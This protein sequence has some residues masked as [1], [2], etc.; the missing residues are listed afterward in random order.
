VGFT[1]RQIAAEAKLADEAAL[2]ALESVVPHTLVQAVVARFQVGQRRQRK[3]PAELV[4]LLT[5]AMSL[6]ATH[7]LERVLAKLLKGLRFIWPEP[8]FALPGRSAICQ[9]RYRLGARPVAA[10]F[11]HVCRPMAT[12]A[13]QGAFYAGLRLMAIDSTTEDVPDS[14][15]N[16]RAFG[17]QTGYR[18]DGA[19]PQVRAVYLVECGSHAIVDAGLWPCHTSERVG[20]LRLLRS[21][22]EGM[23]LLWDSGLHSFAMAAATQR[24]G[25]H[26]LGR[27]PGFA[28]FQPCERLGDG[29]YLTWLYPSYHRRKAG[30]RMLVRLVEYTLSDPARPGYA[31]RHRLLTS[32]LDPGHHPA[33]EL[34]CLYHERWEVELVVDETDTHTRGPHR[35]LRSQRPVGVVQEWYGL[36]IA[37]YAV[38]YLMLQAALQANLDPDRLSFSHA[39]ALVGDALPEFQMVAPEERPALYQRLLRDIAR[40]RLP[41]RRNRT[42]PRVVRRKVFR[43]KVKRPP[44]YYWPQPSLPF[45]QAVCMLN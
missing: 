18:G 24:R 13:T 37:H 11:R 39:L 23:L 5:V 36:L 6:F 17:R 7:S 40:Y 25:A 38:R 43:F 26:F 19:F 1:I 12:P 41:P 33:L 27:V 28:R 9:G 31:E 45:H 21:L 29:S 14:P 4:L 32:L 2:R 20:A 8:E 22:G 10:L 44:H 3:L 42:N 34:A 35:P 30:E 15:Q 16:A